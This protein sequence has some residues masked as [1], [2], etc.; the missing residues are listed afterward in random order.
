MKL[1]KTHILSCL[2]YSTPAVYHA[3]PFMLGQVNNVQQRFL[4]ELEISQTQALQD[5]NLAPLET[6]R[7]IAMLGF[8]HKIVLGK[9]HP[10][11]SDFIFPE[12][13]PAFPRSYRQP[14][15]RHDRQLHD[16]VDASATGAM[17]R[18]LFGLIY[19]YNLLPQ[20][21]V[22]ACSIAAFQAK[23]QRG[24]KKAASQNTPGWE[25]L[26]QAGVRNMGVATFQQFFE[27]P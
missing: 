17:K 11:L 18:S 23:L 13:R 16:P 1:Y 12:R 10:R 7:D 5:Y 22:D 6:R 4:D 27:A 9:A 25:T 19:V 2:E 20:S 8:L 14:A 21:V 26:L 24:I 15:L 3:P